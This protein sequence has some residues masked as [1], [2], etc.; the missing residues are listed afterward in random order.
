MKRAEA[1]L[2][3]GACVNEKDSELLIYALMSLLKNYPLDLAV[4]KIAVLYQKT[5][6]P[7]LALPWHRK[8]HRL[9]PAD[10]WALHH[11]ADC[12]MMLGLRETAR[13]LYLE[14]L[15]LEPR[16]P[17]ICEDLARLYLE[18]RDYE[19]AIAYAKLAIK[20]NKGLQERGYG[21]LRVAYLATGNLKA[22]VKI[23]KHHYKSP[24]SLR[25]AALTDLKFRR[26]TQD[27][28]KR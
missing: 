15:Q 12:C 14:Y 28:Q 16:N 5:G 27:L 26:I 21:I 1:L 20:T 17:H 11:Y 22:L 10:K 13:I 6:R 18:D 4:A 2:W 23:R 8:Y 3:Y 9:N 7:A 25:A 19:K 24:H